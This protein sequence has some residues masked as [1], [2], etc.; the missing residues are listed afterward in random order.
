M[1]IQ[2]D[3]YK[4]GRLLHFGL[5]SGARPGS[6]AEYTE[7]IQHYFDHAEFRRA[8]NEVALGIGLEIIEVSERGVVLVPAD[9]SLFRVKPSEVRSSTGAD[10]R[11][12]EGF[13]QVA[14]AATVY[15][16]AEL[17]EGDP[18]TRRPAITPAEVDELI[19]R[20]CAQLQEETKNHP[21]PATSEVEA[22]LLAGWQVYH[23]R[24]SEDSSRR[25]VGQATLVMIEKALETLAAAGMF[26]RRTREGQT[27]Y[28][29]T[30]RYQVQV[31]EFSANRAFR[32]V[33]D[34]VEK[35]S[36]VVA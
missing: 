13:I 33:Q 5:D 14:I 35:T 11:L 21:D 6:D 9:G 34:A 32:L 22:G 1:S 18:S 23:R 28:Q 3:Y 7:V 20:L 4:I 19:R 31:V 12:L 16:R 24:T 8:V 36:V 17:L 2:P 26:I 10:D 15:P 30:F 27:S 25:R 29:P